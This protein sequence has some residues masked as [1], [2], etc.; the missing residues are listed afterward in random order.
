MCRLA[1]QARLC[2]MQCV[3]NALPFHAA[4]RRVCRW[5]KDCPPARA[6][7]TSYVLVE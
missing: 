7:L 6:S 3:I 4:G 5:L 1:K 2:R